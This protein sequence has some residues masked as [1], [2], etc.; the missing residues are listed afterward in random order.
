MIK[1]NYYTTAAP[2]HREGVAC[3]LTAATDPACPLTMIL[4]H[5][6]EDNRDDVSC[7]PIDHP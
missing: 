2:D 3:S 4:H 1:V 6:H 5:S 7:Q